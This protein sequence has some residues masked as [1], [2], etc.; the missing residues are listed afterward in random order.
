MALLETPDFTN[1]VKNESG[2][3]R[4]SLTPNFSWVI[5]RGFE[6]GK[7]FKQFPVEVRLAATQLKLG[8]NENRAAC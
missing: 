6:Q 5:A 3:V 2:M 7:L 4:F 1:S 8:V